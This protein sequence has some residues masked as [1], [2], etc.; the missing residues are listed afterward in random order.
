MAFSC[1]CH[2]IAASYNCSLPYS[3]ILVLLIGSISSHGKPFNG[4]DAELRL[5]T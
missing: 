2:Y 1:V 4:W 5:M 3:L